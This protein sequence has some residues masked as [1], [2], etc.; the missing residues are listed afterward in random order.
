MRDLPLFMLVALVA[1][2]GCAAPSASPAPTSGPQVRCLDEPR[3]WTGS[4]VTRP[5]FFLFCMQSP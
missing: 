2:G 4:D 1:L 5:L 3:H